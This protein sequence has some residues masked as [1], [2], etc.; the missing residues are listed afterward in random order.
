MWRWRLTGTSHRRSQLRREGQL[1]LRSTSPSYPPP[2]LPTGLHLASSLDSPPRS[3]P[4]QLAQEQKTPP[5]DAIPHH[6]PLPS[7]MPRQTP[8]VVP[9]DTPQGE[10]MTSL[11]MHATSSLRDDGAPRLSLSIYHS[12][13]RY[14]SSPSPTRDTRSWLSRHEEHQRATIRSRYRLEGPG[15]TSASQGTWDITIP[16]LIQSLAISPAHEVHHLERTG[17]SQPSPPRGCG[18]APQGVGGRYH[19]PSRDYA[20]QH[21]SPHLVRPWLGRRG[22]PGMHRG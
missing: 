11:M 2:P 7:S 20:R 8:P 17:A 15:P 6:Q 21:G 9:T 4:C 16:E 3:A 1:A 10:G 14:R 22:D 19:M 13:R 5:S 12:R 18:T